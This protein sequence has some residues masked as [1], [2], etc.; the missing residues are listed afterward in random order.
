MTAIAIQLL[1]NPHSDQSRL[2]RILLNFFEGLHEA[3][4]TMYRYEEL[5]HRSDAELAARKIRR[6]DLPQIA[7]TSRA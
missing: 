1:S 6:Q 3:F 7:I 2:S 4:E 5:S